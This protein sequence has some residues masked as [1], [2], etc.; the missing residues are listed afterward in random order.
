VIVGIIDCLKDVVGQRLRNVDPNDFGTH[1][2]AQGSNFDHVVP[3]VRTPAQ[4][5]ISTNML[6][7]HPFQS[8]GRSRAGNKQRRHEGSAHIFRLFCK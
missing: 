8:A 2:R 6:E 1:L 4:L 3:F 5:V 7:A